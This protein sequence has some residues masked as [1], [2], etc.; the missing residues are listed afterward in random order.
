EK[1]GTVTHPDGRLQR[2]RQSIAHPGEIRPNWSVL[3]DLCARLD[4]PTGAL[5]SPMVFEEMV[6][7]V[8]FYGGLTLDEIG[9]RG[10][11]WPEREQASA[12]QSVPLPETQLD[13]PPELP[14]EG[15]R[16]GT[17]PS[18]WAGPVTRHAAVLRFLT[19]EQTLEISPVDAQ[20]L[21]LSN[22]DEVTVS[23]DGRSVRARAHVR[24]QVQA[25]SVFLLEGTE[26]DNATALMNGLPR[27]VEVVRA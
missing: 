25:G 3:T 16:L 21:G 4:Q 9:G 18:L 12:L 24:D 27:T 17:A 11:R 1:E 8:P 19:P 15:L 7:A 5:S 14:A 13:T 20:R 23:A 26:T 2:V 6:Q 22:G 10:V